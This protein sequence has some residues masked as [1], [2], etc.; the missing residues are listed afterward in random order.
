MEVS[1]KSSNMKKR[2]D[3]RCPL[4]D[5]R[6]PIWDYRCPIW[7]YRCPI[8]YFF[9]KLCFLFVRNTKEPSVFPQM[10]AIQL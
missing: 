6:C 5:Y 10:F 4:W 8:C 9:S 3:Y 1:I 7:D 2:W